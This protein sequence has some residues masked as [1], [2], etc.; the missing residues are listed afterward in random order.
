M[1]RFRS[2]VIALL[3]SMDAALACEKGTGN[4][5][6]QVTDPTFGSG[7]TVTFFPA[8]DVFPVY[9]ADPQRP[10]N[11][12]LFNF[13]ARKEIPLTAARRTGLAAGGRFGF[14]RIVSDG[15]QQRSFQVSMDA[16]LDALFDTQYSNEAIGWDGNYGL[17]F[18]TASK[19]PWSFKAS[20]LHVS[21][22]VGDEYEARLHLK[23]LEY[24]REEFAFAVGWRP[25]PRWRVYGEAARAYQLL[26]ATQEPWRVQ[27]GLEY[28]T[29]SGP[30]RGRFKWYGAADLQA[31]QE[32]GWSLDTAIQAG[33][34]ARSGG[35]SN[36]IFLQYYRGRPTISEFFKLTEITVTTGLKI[37]L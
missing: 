3:V 17:T 15:P 20:L 24:T 26:N 7:T 14:L 19:G 5:C 13:Y 36:R 25:A 33:V 10:T 23:R 34:V 1:R 30:W 18:T 31:M 12:M 29:A 2:V 32:R 16:G 37:D 28:E 35:R 22:H 11:A 8:T 4:A 27:H 9:V 6:D 21:A